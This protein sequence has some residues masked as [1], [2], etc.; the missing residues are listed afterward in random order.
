LAATA[1]ARLGEI[2]KG[3][4]F[5]RRMPSTWIKQMNRQLVAFVAR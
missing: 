4:Q 1:Q 5:R 3:A 2:E